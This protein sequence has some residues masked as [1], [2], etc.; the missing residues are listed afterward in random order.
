MEID[1]FVDEMIQEEADLLEPSRN[2]Y[3]TLFVGWS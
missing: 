1:N 3:L 2:K